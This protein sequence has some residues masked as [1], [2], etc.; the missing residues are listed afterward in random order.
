MSAHRGVC[1]HRCERS[2]VC[3]GQRGDAPACAPGCVH[4]YPGT[5]GWVCVH[6]GHGCACRSAPGVRRRECRGKAAALLAPCRGCPAVPGKQSG[7]F[8]PGHGRP[9]PAP[10]GRTGG[11]WSRTSAP[12]A[13]LCPAAPPSR[14]PPFV[15]GPGGSLS[16]REAESRP[17]RSRDPFTARF[18]SRAAANFPFCKRG[19]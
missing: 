15:R 11:T 7:S 10:G 4:R 9:G 18:Y 8:A 12:H 16:G 14:A 2:W 6:G 19:P 1:V 5:S 17:G 13:G 3:T